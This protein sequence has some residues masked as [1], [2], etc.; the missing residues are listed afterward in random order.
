MSTQPADSLIPDERF[1][2]AATKEAVHRAAEAARERGLNVEIVHTVSEARKLVDGLLPT[3]KT[4]FTASSETLRLSGITE[5]IDESG[6]F[7]SLRTQ[8]REAG[9]ERDF[10]QLRVRSTAP[11]VVVGSV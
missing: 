11:D 5:D 3:D 10:E 9:A 7:V 4:I 6:R 1:A 8:L 2:T